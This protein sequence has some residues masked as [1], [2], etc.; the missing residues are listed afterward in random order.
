M[1]VLKTKTFARWAKRAG[2]TDQALRDAVSE[3][4]QGLI[5]AQLG[6]GVIKKRIAATGR[7]KRGGYRVILASNLGDRWIFMFGFAKNERDNIDEDELRLIKRLASAL[8][9][10]NTHQITNALAAEELIEVH[11][12]K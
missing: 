12:G 1:L 10:M 8:L 3:M 2:V 11:H 5:D 9:I 6:G 4:T 7:G